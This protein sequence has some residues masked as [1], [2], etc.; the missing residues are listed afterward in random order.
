MPSKTK[1]Q[2]RKSSRID[3]RGETDLSNGKINPRSLRVAMAQGQYMMASGKPPGPPPEWRP[4]KKERFD[5]SIKAAYWFLKGK[6]L[7]EIGPLVGKGKVGTDITRQRISQMVGEG[8][9]F[10][11]ARRFVQA[12]D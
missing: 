3:K 6:E 1:T 2:L 5:L 11:L 4:W 10:L 9:R 7:Y 12:V 8:V